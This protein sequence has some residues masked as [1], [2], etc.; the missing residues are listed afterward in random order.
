M[1]LCIC[2]ALTEKRVLQAAGEVEKEGC[3]KAAY[4]KLGVKPQC[5]VCLTHARRLLSA[6]PAAAPA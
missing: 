3:P 2:N 4:R 6:K 1:Y 5:G